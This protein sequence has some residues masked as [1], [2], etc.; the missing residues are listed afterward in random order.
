MKKRILSMA[1]AT[2]LVMGLLTGCGE[3]TTTEVQETATQTEATTE[4]SAETTT[5]TEVA[6]TTGGTLNLAT[7]FWYELDAH[8]DYNGWYS[9]MY[10]ITET[11]FKV[12]DDYSTVPCI[13]ESGDCV[14]N[15]WTIKLKENVVFSNGNP[16]TSA[17]V[18]ANLQ[19][20]GASNERATLLA[21]A[22]FEAVDDYTFTVT[23]EQPYPTLLSD[24]TDP[25]TSIMDIDNIP[26]DDY[27]NSIIGTGPFKIVSYSAEDQISLVKNENYW[28]GSVNLDAVNVYY[29]PDASTESMSL[30]NGEVDIYVGPDV[31]SIALFQADSNFKVT[32]V[33]STKSYYYIFNMDTLTDDAVRQAIMMSVN[34]DDIVTLLAGSVVASEG[35]YGP[36][37]ALGDVKGP[38]YD[39]AAAKTLLEENGYA[40]NANGFYE[41]DGAEITINLAYFAARSID[42]ITTLIQDQLKS[43]GINTSLTL[44]EDP[45]ATYMETGDFDMAMY[46][47]STTTSGDAYSF[48]NASLSSEGNKN[49][50]NYISTEV[51]SLLTTLVSET[52]SAKRTE[53]SLAIQQKALDDHAV[54]YYAMTN[55]VTVSKASVSNC[56]ET[57]PL[58]FY[59][60]SKDSAIQ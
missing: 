2:V 3:T 9:S 4:A 30:Q 19:R 33:A 34:K 20:A 7:A 56:N 46:V 21:A 18:I 55:K 49:S 47:Y 27:N 29:I 53:L 12:G 28:D 13:A 22:T 44:Y 1:L 59:L 24:L 16:V 38:G 57:N 31:D 43:V 10:G 23:T 6:A 36:S 42:K 37:T 45:D 52:D 60:L 14:E 41:K 50:G 8:K 15:V 58:T 5:E 11:L 40:L 51:D 26:E 35:A 17:V 54:G 25:F 48:L 32:S 39:P